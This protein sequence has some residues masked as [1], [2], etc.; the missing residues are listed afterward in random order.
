MKIILLRFLKGGDKMTSYLFYSSLLM[1]LTAPH[2]L[3]K[4]QITKR[5][6]GFPP[7]IGEIEKRGQYVY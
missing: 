1:S 4:S 7:Y 2:T 5:D 6:S 3:G